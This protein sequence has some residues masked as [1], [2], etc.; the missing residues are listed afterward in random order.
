MDWSKL[1]GPLVGLLATGIGGWIAHRFTSPTD[2]QRAALLA[3]I[4]S[5]AAA[6]V[7]ANNPGNAYADMLRDVV[8]RISAAAGVPTTNATAIENAAAG[9]LVRLGVAARADTRK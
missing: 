3:Q 5:D 7:Y 1:L 8:A 2:H 6:A 4:A 9:A